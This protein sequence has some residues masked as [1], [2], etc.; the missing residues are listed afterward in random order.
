M[1]ERRGYL[2]EIRPFIDTDVVKV[3]TGMRRSGKSTLL[4]QI[5]Q[6]LLAR[7]VPKGNIVHI[8]FE[9]LEWGRLASSATAFYEGVREMTRGSAGR[10]YLFFDEVQMVPQWERAVNSFRVDLDCDIYVTG[11]N[12]KLLSGELATLL[13]GRFVSFEVMPFS[14][15]E[16]LEAFPGQDAHRVFDTFAILGGLPFL[17]QVDYARQSSLSYLGDVFNSIVLKDITQRHGI[18]NIDQLERVIGYFIS[19]IGTTYSVKNIANVI[20]DEHRSVSR[21]TIYSYL[22]AAEEAMLLTSVKRYDVKGKALLRGDEKVYITDVGL[23]EAVV[24][25]N[26]RR[27]DI[28]LEN[29]V[30]CEMKRRGYDVFVGRSGVKEIDFVAEKAGLRMY[31][32]VAYVLA[33]ESTVEREFGAFD[34]IDDNFPKYVVSTDRFDMSRN[35]VRHMNIVDFLLDETW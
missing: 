21:D 9:S 10:V 11:S 29:V 30:F 1:I 3:L 27:I 17:T 2:D 22:K 20:E 24:G 4:G 26:G 31:V 25:G 13:S 8:N 28:V 15:R 34:G 16:V 5:Q 32:Q 19:E 7:G 12:S 14:F 35:G 23:R 33:E 18:R 6:E